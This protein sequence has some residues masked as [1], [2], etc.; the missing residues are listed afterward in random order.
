MGKV[1]S[2]DRGCQDQPLYMNEILEDQTYRYYYTA[3]QTALCN[4][5][6]GKGS[7]GTGSTGSLGDKTT[8]LIVPGI[9]SASTISLFK[10][11]I[12]TVLTVLYVL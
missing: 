7:D 10:T 2:M 1:A 6:T 8:V 4:G 9:S 5:G 12:I 3:C 11:M